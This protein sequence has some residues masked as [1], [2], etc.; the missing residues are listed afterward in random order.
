MIAACETVLK[1]QQLLLQDVF[2]KGNT[3][4]NCVVRTVIKPGIHRHKDHPQDRY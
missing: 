4:N 3:K 2:T 1:S